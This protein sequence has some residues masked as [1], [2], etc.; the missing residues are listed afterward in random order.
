MSRTHGLPATYNCGCRCDECS[1][2]NRMRQ[3][4]RRQRVAETGDIS[5]AQHGTENAYVNYSCRCEPC[6]AAGSRH[7]SRNYARRRALASS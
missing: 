7:N 2:A 5:P 3:A 4:R 1:Y 6:R